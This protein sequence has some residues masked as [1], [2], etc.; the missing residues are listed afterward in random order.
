MSPSR[1]SR[2][3]RPIAEINV[4][5]YIDVML[6]LLVIFMITAPLLSEGVKVNLPKTTAEKLAPQ[7]KPPLIVTIDAAGKYFLNGAQA[8]ATQAMTAV[9]LVSRIN[10]VMH[11]SP[12]AAPPVLIKGDKDVDYGK[13]VQV[14]TLLQQAGVNSVGLVTDPLT[15]G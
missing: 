1:S 15:T 5:P 10:D 13:V 14:F 11:Q 8:Q 6:V 12:N 9:E 3:K 7:D 4:V 2:R